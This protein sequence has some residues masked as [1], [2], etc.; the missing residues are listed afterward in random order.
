MP[1]FELKVQR[2][3][4]TPKMKDPQGLTFIEHPFMRSWSNFLLLPHFNMELT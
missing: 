1:A 3:V 2:L 4:S